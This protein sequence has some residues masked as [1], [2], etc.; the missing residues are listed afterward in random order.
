MDKKE[1]E[2][3]S[4]CYLLYVR[5]HTFALLSAVDSEWVLSFSLGVNL[6]SITEEGDCSLIFTVPFPWLASVSYK[7]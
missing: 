4:G 2:V 7:D 5:K 1:K 3:V 6:V